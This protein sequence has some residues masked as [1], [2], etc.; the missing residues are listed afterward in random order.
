[1]GGGGGK[2]G[3]EGVG[4]GPGRFAAHVVKVCVYVCVWM[5]GWIDGSIRFTY[6]RIDS[7]V[8]MHRLWPSS[9]LRSAGAAAAAAAAG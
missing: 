3:V 1:M 4:G 6:M 7:L 2:K 5:D 8:D 9:A